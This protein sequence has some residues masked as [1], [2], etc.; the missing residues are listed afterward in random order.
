MDDT[1][2][3]PLVGGGGK[4][5]KYLKKAVKSAHIALFAVSELLQEIMQSLQVK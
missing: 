4:K 2:E 5:Q 3:I 1:S